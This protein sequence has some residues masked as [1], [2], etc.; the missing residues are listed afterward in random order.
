MKVVHYSA[1]DWHKRQHDT[2]RKKI[3]KTLR[4]LDAGDRDTCME[5]VTFLNT[6]LIDHMSVTDRMMGAFIRN[7]LRFNTALAS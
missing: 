5:L 3:R 6:W 4:Q 1:F 2:I 7:Y